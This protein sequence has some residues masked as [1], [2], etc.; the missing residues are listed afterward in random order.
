MWKPYYLFNK[1]SSAEA[2]GKL[3]SYVG[4]VMSGQGRPTTQM[5]AKHAGGRLGGS[6]PE[7]MAQEPEGGRRD[8]TQR[9]R[10]G[11]YVGNQWLHHSDMIGVL[12][13]PPKIEGGHFGLRIERQAGTGLPFDPPSNSF[14]SPYTHPCSGRVLVKAASEG[15]SGKGAR[16]RFLFF[17]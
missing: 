6:S 4:R 10:Y 16:C 1:K 3:Y 11:L 9:A 15:V 12:R 17:R 8:S 14:R 5:R 7:E 2:H 13:R